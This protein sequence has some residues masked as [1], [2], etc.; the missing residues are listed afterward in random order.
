MQHSIVHTFEVD[1]HAIVVL[2]LEPFPSQDTLSE[3]VFVSF[4]VAGVS[5][6]PFFKTKM[7]FL[8][9]FADMTQTNFQ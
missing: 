6:K 9:G 1:L 7:F 8:Y 2:K 4:V 3:I 5:F